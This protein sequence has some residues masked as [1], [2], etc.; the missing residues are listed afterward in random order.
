MLNGI[1]LGATQAVVSSHLSI[2]RFEIISED[3]FCL[4]VC[5]IP[6]SSNLSFFLHFFL[7]LILLPG[8]I[9]TY[10]GPRR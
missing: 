5:Y 4:C 2:N 3:P 10:C 6:A 1:Q 7:I 8:G 9:V